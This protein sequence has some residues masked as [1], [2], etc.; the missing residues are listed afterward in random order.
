MVKANCKIINFNLIIPEFC[1]M[2]LK[3]IKTA[4]LLSILF[5]SCEPLHTPA[6]LTIANLNAEPVT[7][8]EVQARIPE[9]RAFVIGY[10]RSRYNVSY[11]NL[12]WSK[13]YGD[14]SPVEMISRMTI[15][16]VFQYKI[17]LM[18]ARDLGLITDIS[19]QNFL[20]RLYQEN[21][22]RKVA[23]S[24]KKVIYGPV[25]YSEPIY[26]NYTRASLNI[27]LVEKLDQLTADARKK[28]FAGYFKQISEDKVYFGR[29]ILVNIAIISGQ[30]ENIL[31]NSVDQNDYVLT[32]VQDMLE[33]KTSP[34]EIESLLTDL[35][36]EVKWKTVNFD[37]SDEFWPEFN[38]V[39]SRI[40]DLIAELPEGSSA[41]VGG[42]SGPSILHMEIKKD[43]RFTNLDD[44]VKAM[45]EKFSDL[46]LSWLTSSLLLQ[47]ELQTYPEIKKRIK[48]E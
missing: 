31:I 15:H 40:G 13:T 11:D 36:Y 45:P 23:I 10:F 39:S 27:D 18:I 17:Q 30:K 33:K 29:A 12:F 24:E 26:F 25:E 37:Y 1:F 7:L 46:D 14:I 9:N 19:Y 16:Q 48:V 22:R 28:L 47:S 3:L 43:L 38:N 21:R 6:E 44:F 41:V 35:N 8:A 32:L 20:H 2:N 5:I 42:Q 34:K 4:L